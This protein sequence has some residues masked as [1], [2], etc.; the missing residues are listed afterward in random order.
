[1]GCLCKRKSAGRQESVEQVRQFFFHSPKK[2][3]RRASSEL[4]MSSMAL[5]RV[6][7]K[8]LQMKPYC[9]HL[10]QFLKPTDHIN[11]TNFHIKMQDAMM[12]EGFLDHVV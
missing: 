7:Q 4:E 12:E 3:V 9:L 8:R 10:L 11:R 6:L 5:W 2:S 1:M